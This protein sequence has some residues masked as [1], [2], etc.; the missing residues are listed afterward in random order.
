MDLFT[1]ESIGALLNSNFASALAGALTGAFV[2]A[3]AAHQIADRARQREAVLAEI[4]STNAAIIV[5][6]TIC[7]AG[8]AFKK[9]Q[10][11]EIC[12]T[13]TARRAE[14]EESLRK[15]AAGDG[16]TDVPFQLEAD[17]RRLQMPLVPIDILRDQIYEKISAPARPVALV[18]ALAGSIAGLQ[19]VIE[20]RTALIERYQALADSGAAHLQELYF[21][22]A[23]GPG[24]VST[25]FPDSIKSLH[26]LSDDV[27]FFS[28][29]LISDLKAHGHRVLAKY[30][31]MATVKEEKIHDAEITDSRVTGLMPEPVNYEDWFLGFPDAPR[32]GR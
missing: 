7:N 16:P 10:S 12:D 13:Y 4:R 29:L 9:Q 2:G 22:K 25:E 28:H 24:H 11:K 15:R 6:F 18:A 32:P 31:K 20:K 14:Y 5:A 17:L 30:Q 26:R 21:G 1:W 3:M 19:D 27:I 23:Y 8:L